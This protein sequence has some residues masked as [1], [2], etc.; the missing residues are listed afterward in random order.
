MIAYDAFRVLA[1]GGPG[2][3]ATLTATVI[4]SIA[5]VAV[6]LVGYLGTKVLARTRSDDPDP[7]Q[8]DPE[9]VYL[10]AELL[11]SQEECNKKEKTI[12][13]LSRYCWL[14]GIDPDTGRRLEAGRHAT[15]PP[16][17]EEDDSNAPPQA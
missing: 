6:A 16:A 17:P 13:K 11:K 7:S 10:R 8:E 5:T 1:D 15:P 2:A 4:T 9:V 12:R 14:A 3:S